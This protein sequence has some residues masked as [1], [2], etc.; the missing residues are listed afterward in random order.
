M[1]VVFFFY[2][3]Q[4]ELK[5]VHWKMYDKNHCYQAIGIGRNLYNKSRRSGVA[6]LRKIERQTKGGE[7][8]S[9]NKH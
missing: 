5:S 4:S 6:R 8:V 3:I 7:R 2:L 9:Y 1:F